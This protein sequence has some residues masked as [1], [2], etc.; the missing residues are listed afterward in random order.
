MAKYALR[1]VRR[2]ICPSLHLRSPIQ[3]YNED[4][5]VI[6]RRNLSSTYDCKIDVVPNDTKDASGPGCEVPV[7][8]DGNVSIPS[9]E[10]ETITNHVLTPKTL[11]T[12]PDENTKKALLKNINN[13]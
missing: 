1:L 10:Q 6:R 7:A 3:S 5:L 9:Q 2:A 8:S 4:G 11:V 13:R 12:K